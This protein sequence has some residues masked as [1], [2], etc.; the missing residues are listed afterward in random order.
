MQ[1]AAAGQPLWP[2]ASSM[3][4]AREFFESVLVPQVML[5]GFLGFRPT[6]GGCALD[7]Q[8]PSAWTELTITRIHLH[9]HVLDIRVTPD[10]IEVT[11]HS[12]DARPL[13]IRHAQRRNL[14]VRKGQA[15]HRSMGKQVRWTAVATVAE[16]PAF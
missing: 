7:P 9:D 16:N 1:C 10:A 2:A 3:W 4:R 8:I 5:Y 12:P 6:V 11:D 13:V 14:K 15:S